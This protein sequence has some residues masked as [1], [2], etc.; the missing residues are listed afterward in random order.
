[1]DPVLS[2]ALDA[3]DDA[4]L[5]AC[6][7]EEARAV[8]LAGDGSQGW[9][10][11]RNMVRPR[12]AD[13]SPAGQPTPP[14]HLV[15]DGAG[16]PLHRLADEMGLD[17][18]DLDVVVLVLAPHVDPRYSSVYAVLQDDLGE[19]L[20]TE[21]LVRT[22][23]P[24]AQSRA[25]AAARLARAGVVQ[26]PGGAFAPLAQPLRL[27]DDMVAALL[28]AP[29]PPPVAGGTARRVAGTGPAIVGHRL[30]VVHGSGDRVS[31]AQHLAAAGTPL[32]LVGRPREAA[33]ALAVASAA[34]RAGIAEATLPV[35]D[36]SALAEECATEVVGELETLIDDLGGRAWVL[37]RRPVPLPVPHVEVGPPGW[38]QRRE[39][40]LAETRRAGIVLGEDDAD[41]LATRYRFGAGEI[42]RAVADA[43]PAAGA[44]GLADAAAA[45]GSASVRHSLRTV[46]RR[47]FDDVVLRDT[48]RDALDRLVFFM[49]HRDRV[50][51]ERELSD[52]L[53]VGRGPV[54]LFSGQ[55]GTGKTLSAEV[56]AAA[57]DRPLHTVN[58]SQLV[59]KYIG[60]TE[61]HIDEV[62]DQ[63]EAASA[64]LLF[65]EADA[66]FATRHEDAATASEQFGN[67]LVGYLLQRIETHDGLVMLSTNL[68]HAIDDAFLRRFHF[69]IEFPLPD[70]GER[71]AIWDLL[72]PAERGDDLEL[73][74]L[75]EQHR[76]T[77][78]DIRNAA[79]RAVFLAEARGAVVGRE[80]VE[81]A[82]A[83]EMLEMGR[84]SRRPTADAAPD[85]GALLRAFVDELTDQLGG[86][87]QERFL[88]EIR[89]VHGSP[90]DDRL[91]GKRPAVSLAFFR[92][93][94]R[95]GQGH[96]RAGF[97]ISAWSHL[98]EE[99][100]ELLGVVDEALTHL[101]LGPA[102]GQPVAVRVSESNDFDLLHRFWSSHGHP[103]RPSLVLDVEIG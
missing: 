32:L 3:L 28:G 77:G 45:L 21:R 58:L 40:W 38:R 87:L 74:S 83:L 1:M 85:R 57:V 39:H 6:H 36:L 54:V 56:V 55:S 10:G 78:G 44:T 50:A 49:L 94:S 61:K 12:T 18:L 37:T 81:R 42:R 35:V 43:D 59:S 7:R 99:E 97:M 64:V 66:L 29:G 95:R 84:L 14:P 62:L 75:A 41:R 53:A 9:A 90:T 16:H 4:L 70:A 96:V 79:L 25:S 100:A 47:T 5:A 33:G 20:P 103:V 65:D 2:T 68:R 8:L 72:L 51:A 23:L 91:S 71:A 76:L 82:V 67:M 15:G 86:Y 26:R 34:W 24:G 93:A 92:L 60:E 102:L 73:G 69:R 48:T 80:D 19:P 88:K 30:L 46:P 11:V 27:A 31:Q 17:A 89:V 22:V 98:A 63:A 101:Q 52:G 13:L